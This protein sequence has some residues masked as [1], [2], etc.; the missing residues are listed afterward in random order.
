MKIAAG[1]RLMLLVFLCLNLSTIAYSQTV[2]LGSGTAINTIT[3]SSP[4]N[5]WY[6]K[7]VCQMVY[8]A[9]ELTAAGAVAGPITQLDFFVTNNPIYDL[10]G[11]EIQMKLTTDPDAS[12]S[13]EGGYTTVISLGS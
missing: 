11:Y 9:E 3:S 5:I 6:R 8:T 4:I 2:T 7:T 13:L 12:C 1:Q 10:P